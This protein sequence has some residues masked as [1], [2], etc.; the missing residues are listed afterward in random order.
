MILELTDSAGC[1]VWGLQ[2]CFHPH[3]QELLRQRCWLSHCPKSYY[4]IFSVHAFVSS[5]FLLFFFW[6]GLPVLAR[7][8]SKSW[9]SL[10][11]GWSVICSSSLFANFW[12]FCHFLCSWGQFDLFSCNPDAFLC[13]FAWANLLSTWLNM[14]PDC[15]SLLGYLTGSLTEVWGLWL[16]PRAHCLV[17]RLGRG[18]RRCCVDKGSLP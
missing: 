5:A 9:A 15:F 13:S 14:S 12:D 2:A 7:L 6:Q 16:R 4:F 8:A 18:F 3:P 11:L 1:L 10:R 17:T